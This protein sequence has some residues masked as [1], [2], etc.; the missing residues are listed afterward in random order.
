MGTEKGVEVVDNKDRDSIVYQ[1][2]LVASE[3][4]GDEVR[5][6]TTFDTQHKEISKILRSNWRIL[7]ND[8]ILDPMI[9]DAPSITYRKNRSLRDMLVHSDITPSMTNTIQIGKSVV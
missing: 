5:F 7:H 3:I 9:A 1:Q 2:K 8:A 6:V 4:Q